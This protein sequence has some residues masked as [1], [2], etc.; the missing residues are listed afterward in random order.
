MTGRHYVIN[1]ERYPSVTTILNMLEKS[2]LAKWR[3]SVG[4]I[5]ADR[6][7]LE[8]TTHGT[9][10]HSLVEIVNRGNRQQLGPLERA[11][12]DPYVRWFDENVSACLAAEKLLSSRQWK[13]AGTT[14]A[15]MLML[16]DEATAIVDFKTSKTDLAQREWALQTAAY[17]LAAEEEEIEATRRIIVRIP[18]SEPGSLYVTEFPVDEL[19]DDQRAFLAVLRVFQ[20]HAKRGPVRRAPGPRINF[21][22][23]TPPATP[24]APG[25]GGTET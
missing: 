18:K 10:I 25:S 14:D 4:N 13:F 12:I 24:A 19:L 15:I 11:I 17:A 1:G 5:E 20:W 6:I 8:A 3:G 2:G 22:R 23:R 7:S 9:A 16:A 21:A